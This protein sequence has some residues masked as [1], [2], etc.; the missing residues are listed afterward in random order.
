MGA[1]GA[2][3]V[4]LANLGEIYVD[5]YVN[6]YEIKVKYCNITVDFIPGLFVSGYEADVEEIA[7][8]DH[9]SLE[10]HH[11]AP[12]G[13]VSLKIFFV[14]KKKKHFLKAAFFVSA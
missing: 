4:R 12:L 13:A 2:E 3:L 5:D 1:D 11:N 6:D 10:E 7:E 9:S 14:K 8:E